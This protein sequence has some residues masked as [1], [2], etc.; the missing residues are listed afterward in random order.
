MWHSTLMLLYISPTLLLFVPP[1]YHTPIELLRQTP[2]AGY[3]HLF[4]KIF[5]E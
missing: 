3:E 5:H 4:D 1:D 2:I